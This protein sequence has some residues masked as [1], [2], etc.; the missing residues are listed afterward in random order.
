MLRVK[1]LAVIE[2]LL[3]IRRHNILEPP[4]YFRIKKS[5]PECLLFPGNTSDRLAKNGYR[6]ESVLLDQPGQHGFQ[7]EDR[8]VQVY[9]TLAVIPFHL[10]TF[11]QPRALD[12][13]LLL[14][15]LHG[16]SNRNSNV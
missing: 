10:P 15:V 4:H 13:G 11:Q 6:A 5:L 8:V 2:K 14:R 12:E 7:G 1:Y 9:S 16:L 3:F